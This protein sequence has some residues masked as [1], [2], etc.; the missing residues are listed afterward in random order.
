MAD[1][2]AALDLNHCA[3]RTVARALASGLVADAACADRSGLAFFALSPE[4][5]AQVGHA[6][7][8]YVD[9]QAK[10]SRNAVTPAPLW[11]I[12]AFYRKWG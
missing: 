6:A 1:A 3:L 2:V 11:D 7:I 5:G 8:V 10:Q 4:V 12:L 9:V